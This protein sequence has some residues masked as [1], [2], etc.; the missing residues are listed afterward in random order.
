M[1]FLIQALIKIHDVPC[2]NHINLKRN[3]QIMKNNLRAEILQII[4]SFCN[5]V[6]I[7]DTNKW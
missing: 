6:Y 5:N 7:T 4:K 1:D 2:V 3:K